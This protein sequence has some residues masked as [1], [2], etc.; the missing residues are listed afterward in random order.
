[1]QTEHPTPAERPTPRRMNAPTPRLAFLT[2][3]PARATRA[4][5]R[6]EGCFGGRDAHVLSS[7]FAF[8][9]A[10]HAGPGQRSGPRPGGLDGDGRRA[11]TARPARADRRA[12]GHSPSSTAPRTVAPPGPRRGEPPG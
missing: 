11:H 9:P 2:P 1:M 5:N 7:P 8:R 3:A 4:E 10:P 6:I 12:A